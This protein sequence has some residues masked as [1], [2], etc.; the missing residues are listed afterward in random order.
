MEGDSV[1]KYTVIGHPYPKAEGDNTVSGR[2]KYV[3]DL[4]PPYGVLYGKVVRSPYPRA[5]IDSID[6]KT[7]EA[8][9]DVK[10]I[11]TPYNTSGKKYGVIIE[12]ET[13]LTTEPKFIGDEVAAV[14]AASEKA[15]IQAARAIKIQYE[16][17]PANFTVEEAMAPG[18]A[19]VHKN[20][21]NIAHRVEVNTG[22]ASGVLA[23]S[24]AKADIEIQTKVQLQAPLEHYAC[25]ASWS[26]SEGLIVKAPVQDPSITHASLASVL[27]L[28]MSKVRV[29]QTLIGGSYG[30]KLFHVKL[31]YIC[32]LLAIKTG[33]QVFMSHTT[34][35]EFIAG[36]PR[37][38]TRISIEL[39]ADNKGLLTA[40]KTRIYADN[41]A[42]SSYA[43]GPVNVMSTRT[44]I[45]YRI[46]ILDN[47]ACLV[48]TNK[49]PTAGMR[50]FGNISMLFALE[51][52][53]D[54]LAHKLQIDPV[55]FRKRNIYKEG[56]PAPWAGRSIV[57][58]W[59]SAWI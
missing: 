20:T 12:D 4:V 13:V 31:T 58:D 16:E 10:A 47:K 2:N 14:A 48:Y 34:E 17:L 36:R 49:L 41:G 6:T 32:C 11:L 54:E 37:I 23:A 59:R 15:A 51:S 9:P 3:A 1:D 25:L 22:D 39:G 24:A 5:R 7:A 30:S 52:A 43:P 44:H 50:G 28:P 35:E 53:V 40:Q 56:K 55:E 38:P 46:P 27:G 18:A 57:H 42:Y 26:D 45:L 29:I 21:D 33:Q 8:D 19:L